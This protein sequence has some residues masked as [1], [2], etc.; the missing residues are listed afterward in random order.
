MRSN[1]FDYSKILGLHCTTYDV[2]VFFITSEF[3]RNKR[4]S[5]NFHIDYYKGGLEIGYDM[6]IGKYLMVQLGLR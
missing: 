4:I 5:Y 1:K 3:S 6:I 2:K